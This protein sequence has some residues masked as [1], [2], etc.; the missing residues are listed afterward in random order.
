MADSARWGRFAFREDDVVI[1]D[2]L[3]VR[4][5]LDADDRRHAP[6]RHGRP[7]VRRSASSRRGSTCRSTPMTRCSDVLARQTHRRFIKTPHAAGRDPTPPV[8]DLPRGRSATRSTS[9]S[10]IATTPTTCAAITRWSSASPPSGRARSRCRPPGGGP[11]RRR[12]LPPMVHRQRQPAGG[13]R[14]LRTGRLLPAGADLLGRRAEPNV[15]LFHYADLWP[16]WTVRCGAW[17]MRSASRSTRGSGRRSSR[18]RRWARCGRARRRRRPTPTR[19]CGARPRRSSAWAGPGSG[20]HCWTGPTSSTSTAGSAISRGCVGLGAAG[21]RGVRLIEPVQSAMRLRSVPTPSA[22]SSTV[23]PGQS[24]RSR[25]GNGASA[26]ASPR[27]SGPSC[28][29]SLIITSN[30]AAAPLR[31][32]FATSSPSTSQLQEHRLRVELVGGDDARADRDGEAVGVSTPARRSRREPASRSRA[33]SRRRGAA[34][35]RASSGRVSQPEHRGDLRLVLEPRGARRATAPPARARRIRRSTSIGVGRQERRGNSGVRIAR[36][37][38]PRTSMTSSRA[39]AVARGVHDG[40]SAARDE[41][42]ERGGEG[43]VPDGVGQ[44]DHLTLEDRPQSPLPPAVV[45]DEPHQGAEAYARPADESRSRARLSAVSARRPAGIA[46]LGGRSRPR[47][48]C[49]SRAARARPRHRPRGGRYPWPRSSAS[50]TPPC[51]PTTR[52]C[53][54]RYDAAAERARGRARQDLPGHRQRRGALARRDLRRAV[55]DRRGHR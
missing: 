13:Q 16:I 42:L 18:R 21:T 14:A 22:A 43:R 39:S 46:P 17:P 32:P 4:D 27:S 30:E 50:P 10:R 1:D 54:P 23:A 49:R 26:N 36:P 9:R 19:A 15:H 34:S 33:C 47:I 35:L 45:G 24:W 2:A 52:S 25:P 38:D 5:D 7:R 6:A 11:R 3:E 55:A 28:E 41:T 48:P 31:F 53:R 8:G 20:P 12:R 51:P 40:A 44:V 29:A 37:L